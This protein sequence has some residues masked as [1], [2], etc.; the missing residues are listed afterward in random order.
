MKKARKH[1]IEAKSQIEFIREGIIHLPTGSGKTFIQAN[2]I[3][4][5][6]DKIRVF[7][8]LS[9]R[10]LLTNQLYSEVKDILVANTRDCQYLIVHSGRKEDKDDMNW[11]KDMPYREVISTTSS[12]DIKDQYER[13]Q[14]ENVPLIIFST[15]DSAIR[16]VQSK[17]PVY[18]LLCDEAHNLVNEEFCWIRYDGYNDGR[19][20]FNANRKYYF[21]ATL[22]VTSS[23]TGLGMNNSDEYGPIIYS[24]TPL[25]MIEAGE[26]LRPRMHLVN[27]SSSEIV[28][29]LDKDVNAILESFTEHRIH[30]KIG[31]KLLVVTKGSEHLNNIV[32]HPLIQLEIDTRPN[33]KIFDISS[34]YRPRIN[35]KEVKRELFLKELQNMDERDEAVILHVKILSEGIDVPGITGIMV[36]NNL[37]MS[38]FLQTLGRATRLYHKDRSNLYSDTIKYNE[39]NKF[40]K[41]YA[42]II[43]PV[44]GMIGD[45]LR[46]SIAEMVYS[47]RT[48]G[49]NASEDVV[50]K[51]SKGK[52]MPVPLSGLNELDTR[53]MSYKAQILD[54]VHDVEEKEKADKLELDN[55]AL[56]STVMNEEVEETFNRFKI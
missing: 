17:I 44:Y 34:A 21:T 41:P 24:K 5:N 35:G 39:L 36:M 27:V 53:A 22:K 3:V 18:M 29:E 2:A 11:A 45:D 52:A 51:E 20:Q 7:V 32:N 46:A 48:Y 54:I 42:W 25:E 43:I 31:S 40:T 8:V 50:I 19:L 9:P 49:F 37:S 33:L 56:K 12:I 38:S 47:L 6:F 4:D 26:I 15:Y 1:Q 16:I 30:C 10:I 23:E 13:A 55:F 28:T 14:R